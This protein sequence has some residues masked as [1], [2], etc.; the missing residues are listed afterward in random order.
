MLTLLLTFVVISCKSTVNKPE[1]TGT[2][3]TSA[4]NGTVETG[5][6]TDAEGSTEVDVTV[7]ETTGEKLPDHETTGEPSTDG[8]MAE[9]G[10]AARIYTVTWKNY[11]GTVLETASVEHGKTPTYTGA[12]PTRATTKKYTY[13]FSRWDREAE[14]VTG[15]TTYTAQFSKTSNKY[16][17][18]WKNYD[19]TVL[20]TDSMEYGATPSYTG[21]VPE[22]P[23]NEGGR[24][25]F[26]GWSPS[27]TAVIQDVTYTAWF[28]SEAENAKFFVLSGTQVT[29][30]TAAG[31]EQSVLCIPDGVTSIEDGAFWGCSSLTSVTIPDSVTSIGGSAFWECT[32]LTSVTLPD[33]VASIGDWAFYKCSGLQSI[34]IPERVTSIGTYVFYACT[35]LTSVTLPDGLTSLGDQAFSRCTGLTDITIPDS[36]TEIGFEAFRGCIGLTSVTIPDGVTDIGG[37]VFQDCTGLTSILLPDGMTC[38]AEEMFRDCSSLA[39]ISIPDGV[40]EIRRCAF[41]GCSSMLTITIPNGVTSIGEGTFSGCAGLS[42]VVIPSGVTGIGEG[43]FSGCTGLISVTIPADVTNIGNDA[44]NSERD[45]QKTQQKTPNNIENSLQMI[46]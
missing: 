25:L 11:D 44:I 15:D 4:A 6:E 8:E 24:Y 40:R 3:V 29:G 13:S 21:T 18:T 42:S 32:S 22:K 34:E 37:A 20:A 17:V 41:S 45:F 2:N 46:A 26:L 33:R 23:A 36:V 1:E 27:V 5:K 31:K 16:T 9:T 19:G 39:S 28:I 35:S 12:T 38:I 14:A 7:A 10:T 43:M 30:V